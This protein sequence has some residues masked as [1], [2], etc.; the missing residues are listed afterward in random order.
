MNFF[1]FTI[2]SKQVSNIQLIYMYE[3]PAEVGNNVTHYKYLFLYFYKI[4]HN[5]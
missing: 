1:I 5:L 2:I 3:V 4:R